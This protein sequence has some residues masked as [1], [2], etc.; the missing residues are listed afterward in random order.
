MKSPAPSLFAVLIALSAGLYLGRSVFPRLD[1]AALAAGEKA[2]W[3]ADLARK[4]PQ[5]Y[6]FLAPALKTA[7]DLAANQG[8]N[9][10][11]LRDAVAAKPREETAA[12]EWQVLTS[13]AEESPP[14]AGLPAGEAL[15][16]ER[17]LSPWFAMERPQQAA[18]ITAAKPKTGAATAK[19]ATAAPQ[20]LFALRAA[21]AAATEPAD[22]EKAVS[23]FGRRI[24]AVDPAA[25]LTWLGEVTAKD[26]PFAIWGIA[27]GWAS[28][29]PVEAV[30]WAVTLTDGHERDAAAQGL[31]LGGA[32]TAPLLVLPWALEI[33]E[34]TSRGSAV[35][36]VLRKISGSAATAARDFI[37][38]ANLPAQERKGY[39]ESLASHSHG[40][41]SQQ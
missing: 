20:S 6:A 35:E 39:L 2:E 21:L 7:A 27:E 29:E 9:W 22:L 36:G 28:F 19:S 14:A 11:S 30:A 4:K 37:E 26:R 12:A 32:A 8:G 25:G 15:L 40:L 24:G 16:A 18:T 3:E 10:K 31:A 13:F 17:S 1:P 41:S 33:V 5:Q 34:P 38:A 23:G